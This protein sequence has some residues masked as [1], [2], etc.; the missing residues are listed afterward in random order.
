MTKMIRAAAVQASPVFLD[1]DAGVEK[2]CA[3]IREAARGG[4]DLVA[5]P[6]AFL[7]GYP[8]WIWLG[9][10]GARLQTWFRRF[11]KNAV[12]IPGPAVSRLSTAARENNI[13]VNVS[14][15]EREG[16]SLYLTQL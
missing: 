10:P 14:V 15:T 3:I 4:A 13:Y 11:F 5:L 16:G 7:P 1:P 12:T 9:D 6:E 8:Y 2:A